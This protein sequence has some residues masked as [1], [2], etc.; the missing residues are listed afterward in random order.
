MAQQG[1]KQLSIFDIQDANVENQEDESTDTLIEEA[2]SWRQKYWLLKD[3]VY[4]VGSTLLHMYA[5]ELLMEHDED[6]RDV[7]FHL[8]EIL[9]HS[10]DRLDKLKAAI[11]LAAL[12]DDRCLGT[13]IEVLNNQEISTI[14]RLTLYRLFD[15]LFEIKA[16][17][18]DLLDF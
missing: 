3:D 9:T 15:D 2:S 1:N 7:V 6:H 4:Y 11:M 17:T 10:H 8:C 5:G 13:L 12:K 14:T 18:S 16:V